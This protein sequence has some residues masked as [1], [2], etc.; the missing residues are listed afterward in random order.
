MQTV[1]TILLIEDEPDILNTNKEFFEMQGYRAI[2]A[3]NLFSARAK[4][5]RMQ[6]DLIVSDIILPDGSG[7]DFCREV[8]EHSVV[9]I[10]FLSCLSMEQHIIDGLRAGGD[11]YMT[12]P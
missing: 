3:E 10:I 8:R 11:D 1:K 5:K 2:A 4:M 9:P 7:L 12:K 6:I